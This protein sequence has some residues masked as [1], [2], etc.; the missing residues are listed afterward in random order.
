VV[1][2]H[3]DYEQDAALDD[4][5]GG[6]LYSQQKNLPKLP[7]PSIENTL[8]IFL[9]SALPLAESEEEAQ[10]L[11]Q[12]CESFPQEALKL[13]E[14]LEARRDETSDSSWLQLWWNQE[15]YLKYREPVV[16]NVSYFFNIKHD[17][18][19]LKDVEGK[20][21]GVM[22][23]AAALVALGQYRKQVCS[24]QTPQETIGKKN[25]PLCS[26]AFKYMFHG[27]R[28][29]KKDQDIYKMYDPSLY[30]HCIVAVKGQFFAMDFVDAENN[31]EPLL[32][33]SLEA[34]LMK[35][36]ALAEKNRNE[37]HGL[38]L[39]V[40]TADHRDKWAENRE[41]LLQVGGEAMEKALRKLESG[42]IVLCL[43]DDD[44]ISLRQL[45]NTFWHG[46]NESHINRWFDKS[47]NLM[48]QSN[49][50]L[51]F[52]GEHSMADA[53]PAVGLCE[54]IAETKYGNLVNTSRDKSSAKIPTVENIFGE[55]MDLVAKNDEMMSCIEEC[56]HEKFLLTDLNIFCID[57]QC[58]SH[59]LA[60][61]N[62]NSSP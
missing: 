48:C 5:I 9:P 52:L 30:K 46:Y 14:R 54:C 43:D 11:I 20:P 24:G 1:V 29:P 42:A 25:I 62:E 22:R 8:K 58:I 21:L 44:P 59:L 16:I 37:H 36:I 12:A 60:F 33:E 45:S 57:D 51:G 40:L 26:T 47:I 23:G 32:L 41:R 6:P 61:R 18:E 49:G 15:G 10:N 53:M 2:S 35:C 31:D 39:G 13:Q 55:V 38:D 50:K 17:D 19:T 28:I 27:C 4:F 56:K 34:G 3:G 7:V